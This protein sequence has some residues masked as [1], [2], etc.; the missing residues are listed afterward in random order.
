MWEAPALEPLSLAGRSTSAAS[1]VSSP[2]RVAVESCCLRMLAVL[3]LHTSPARLSVVDK[4]PV[5]GAFVRARAGRGTVRGLL[6][7]YDRRGRAQC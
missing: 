6:L 5:T 7:G 4:G 3:T 1:P 2:H